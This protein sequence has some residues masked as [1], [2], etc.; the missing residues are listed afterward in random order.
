MADQRTIELA[1]N[2][3]PFWSR[4]TLT[5]N[6]RFDPAVGVFRIIFEPGLQIP[7]FDYRR[8]EGN[9]TALEGSRSTERDTILQKANETR[10]GEK[11]IIEGISITKDGYP[12]E[13]ANLG[14]VVDGLQHTLIPPSSVA[15]ANGGLVAVGGIVPTV[16]DFRALDSL[17]LEI[18]QKYFFWE[19]QIDGTRRILQMGPTILYPGV[20]GPQGGNVD[21]TNGGTFVANYMH[22]PET[23]QW[24]PSGVRDSNLVALLKSAY[25]CRVPTWTAPDGLDDAGA[26]IPNAVP[27]ALGRI[28]TQGWIMNFHGAAIS[29]VSAIS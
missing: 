26:A 20:G 13:R 6:L 10:G 9:V 21:T 1:E 23:I 5:A 24:N 15:P 25:R 22:I 7:V 19:L 28:W 17:M 14:Q 16:E 11:Y 27:T 29:P 4:F 8:G 2:R 12:Y 18:L 3:L